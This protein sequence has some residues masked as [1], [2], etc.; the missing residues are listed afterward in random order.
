MRPKRFQYECIFA[1][2]LAPVQA[3]FIEPMLCR[4][5]P[6]LPEG[7]DWRYEIKL[8]GYRA[9]GVK[10]HGLAQLWS[11]NRKDFTRRFPPV[12]EGLAK[13]PDETVLDGEI[14]ALDG[15]GMP[16]FHWLQN[17]DGQRDAIVFYAFDLPLLGGLDLR[18]QPLETRREMLREIVA[19]LPSVIRFSETFDVPASE[20][21]QIV[22]EKGLEGFVAKRCD[23]TYQAGK[24]SDDWV[25][26]RANQAAE[27]VLGGYVPTARSF[28]SI[29]VG[30]FDGKRL[31]YAGSIRA[32]FPTGA[33]RALM[34]EL[35]KL[36]A[37][38]CPFANLPER[39]HGRWGEGITAD[40]M[41]LCRWLRPRIVARIEFLEWTDEMR[42]RHPRFAG[43]AS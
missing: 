42:L 14:V 34:P 1:D 40:R 11:R 3:N 29:L 10:S 33:R 28:D 17:F 8:D 24:R 2:A 39:T 37:E 30:R 21:M 19:K 32:G 38:R 15:D 13:L 31:M 22:R 5:A 36:G 4:T 35:E 41:E 20:L 16:A 6:E 7:L 25:K 26:V 12:A 43:F 27:F 9:I 23:S 18:R